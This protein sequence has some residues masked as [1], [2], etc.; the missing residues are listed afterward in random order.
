[1]RA[2][3]PDNEEARLA[4]L[5][6]LGIVDQ[7]AAS[8]DLDALSR[9]AVFVTGAP[10]SAINL[11]DADR[12]W[13]ASVAGAEPVVYPRGDSLCQHTVYE[14]RTIHVADAGRD[15]RFSDN[16]FVTGEI[17]R[18]ALYCGVPLRDPDGYVLGTLCITDSQARQLTAA[19]VGALEDLAKQVERM[20]EMR[21]QHTKLLDVLAELDHLAVHD[22]LTG[23]V[24]RRM[25]ADRLEH[26]LER[27]R[28]GSLPPVVFFGDLDGFKAVNDQLGHQ[29]GDQV[30]IEV[31]RRLHATMRPTD[32]IARVGGDELVVLCE[33]L[34]AEHRAVVAERIRSAA[35]GS[36]DTDAGPAEIGLSIGMAVAT[37]ERSTADVLA[38]ADRGMYL[39]K[40]SRRSRA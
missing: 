29:A 24:N 2:P 5:H 30:L 35:T 32:T 33:D 28:R 9:L 1:V 15:P 19:Q 37:P 16:P 21:R 13:Q 25:L 20:F 4:A 18:V 6:R 7:P 12:Q 10:F 11:I 23:L 17:D 26:A 31:A 34:P 40:L 39:D 36:I 3:V 8:P 27:A 38:E 22:P 14:G